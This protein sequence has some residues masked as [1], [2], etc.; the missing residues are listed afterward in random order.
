VQILAGRLL[1][2]ATDLV[3]S[4]NGIVGN[5][6]GAGK[7]EFF[8]GILDFRPHTRT[9]RFPP[10]PTPSAGIMRQILTGSESVI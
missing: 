6:P 8:N 4:I 5:E 1:L 2:S 10:E 7:L 9:P 3:K